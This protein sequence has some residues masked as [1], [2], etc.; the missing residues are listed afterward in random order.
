MGCLPPFLSI[1]LLRHRLP[2]NLKLAYL[3]M[4]AAQGPLF[5]T[6]PVLELQTC[7]ATPGFYSDAGTELRF[8]YLSAK[9]SPQTY[10]YR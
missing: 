1:F 5:S 2:L 4:L 3:A 6:S 7:A 10:V 8:S 9:P